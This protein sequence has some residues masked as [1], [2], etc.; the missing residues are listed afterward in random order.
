MACVLF[1]RPTRNE[2]GARDEYIRIQKITPMIWLTT[3]VAMHAGCSTLFRDMTPLD[4]SKQGVSV[5]ALSR[6]I[7]VGMYSGISAVP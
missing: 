6:R 3:I 7:G 1:Q 4:R 2:A 5:V